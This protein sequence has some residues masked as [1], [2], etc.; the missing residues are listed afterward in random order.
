M[1]DIDI[2]SHENVNQIYSLF[3]VAGHSEEGFGVLPTLRALR[4]ALDAAQAVAV[5]PL[6][7]TENA[8]SHTYISTQG[9][10]TVKIDGPSGWEWRR[11]HIFG[12]ADSRQG[13]FDAANKRHA[14]DISCF[15]EPT[16]P[17]LTIPEPL[18]LEKGLRNCAD[19][20]DKELSRPV[21]SGASVAVC[22]IC[23]IAGCV[24]LRGVGME[25]LGSEFETV[26]DSSP[27]VLYE[28]DGDLPILA[29]Q[30]APL[31]E[32]AMR[33]RAAKMQDDIAATYAGEGDAGKASEYTV[34]GE[35]I[36]AL[37]ATFTNA[38]LLAA[39]MQLPEVEALVDAAK[40]YRDGLEQALTSRGYEGESS[41]DDY[42]DE[43]AALAPF[44]RK[45][46]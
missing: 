38:E 22:P 46:E 11:G 34:I 32:V 12:F 25:P 3:R 15:L 16:T 20:L 31:A 5:K 10:F 26:L 19:A 29:T 7:W 1:S 14:H 41:M 43:D 6:V 23:D 35:Y 2:I 36:R 33:E 42:S 30:S 39:A 13:A 8:H 21:V 27:D 37:P 24:H 9:G 17:T 28:Y 40:S 45:G 4:A 18:A 44:T